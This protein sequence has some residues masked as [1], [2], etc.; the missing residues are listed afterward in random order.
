MTY[1]DTP[2]QP[3]AAERLI[4]ELEADWRSQS[5]CCWEPTDCGRAYMRRRR[6]GW[7][8]MGAFATLLCG[9]AGWLVMGFPL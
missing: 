9:F 2:D 3:T 7:A 4:A 5:M 8:L 1:H 6:I